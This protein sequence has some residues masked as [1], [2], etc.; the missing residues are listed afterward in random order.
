MSV[1][2]FFMFL[3]FQN[4]S[5]KRRPNATKLFGDFFWYINQVVLIQVLMGG[6]P[7]YSLIWTADPV[8]TVFTCIVKTLV[9]G[10]VAGIVYKLGKKINTYLGTVCSALICPVTNTAIFLIGSAVFF[11]DSA[12]KI[13]ERVGIQGSGFSVFVALALANFVFEVLLNVVLCP[14]IVRLLNIRKK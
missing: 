5:T 6:N 9:A 10:F 2:V 1:A 8:V 14:V 4:I 11:L 3:V 13:A 7:F 12:S